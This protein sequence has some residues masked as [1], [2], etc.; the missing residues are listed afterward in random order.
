[1]KHSWV[2]G[3]MVIHEEDLDYCAS[4]REVTCERCDEVYIVGQDPGE[5]G[6]ALSEDGDQW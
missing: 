5:C 2:G 4:V 3:M 6:K 1:M